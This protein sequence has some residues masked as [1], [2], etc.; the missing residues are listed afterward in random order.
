MFSIDDKLVSSDLFDECFD[1]DLSCCKGVCCVYGDSGAPL[2]KNERDLIEAHL[3]ALL[4]FLSEAGKN[5][6]A[7]KGVAEIDEDAELVT[8][9]VGDKGECAYSYFA[10]DGMCLCAIEKACTLGAVPF[11]KPVSCHLYPIRVENFNGVA[12]LN[13]DRW[14][15]CDY[16]RIKGFENSVPVFRFLKDAIIRKFGSEFYQTL[17]EVDNYKL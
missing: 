7:E 5:A 9:L 12:A 10:D 2:E 8:T 1:C 4:P 14:S 3:D 16:A 11:N 17:E 13:Y 6:I 15:I